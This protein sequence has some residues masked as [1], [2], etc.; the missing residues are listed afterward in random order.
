[1]AKTLFQK[2]TSGLV[3][4]GTA[5]GLNALN[6]VSPLELL[7]PTQ[8]GEASPQFAIAQTDVEEETRVRVYRQASPAVVSI[9]TPANTGSG[10]IVREDGLILTNAHVVAGASTVQVILADGTELTGDVIAF[11]DSGLDLAAVKVHGQSNLPTIPIADPSSVAV[12]QSAFAIGTPFGQFQN[13]FTVGIVSRIDRDRGLIQTDAAINPGNSGGPL[14][15]SRGELIGVNTSIFT[16]GDGGNIGLGFAISIDQVQPFL[17]AIAE[18]RASTTAQ[19]FP[20]GAGRPPEQI[21]LNAQ[22]IEGRLDTG[23]NVLPFDNSYYNTY[24]FE[25]QAGQQVIVEMSSQ[26]IDAYLIL[27]DPQGRELS[28]DDDSGGSTNARIVMRL[29]EDGTYT[30]LA[31]SYGPN[32]AGN[33]T[34]RVGEV[35]PSPATRTNTSPSSIL[36][37]EQGTLGRGSLVLPEDGSYYDEYSFQGRSGQRVTITLESNEFDPYLIVF[38]PDGQLL[39]QNDDASPSTT[40]SSISVTL[41]AS[42]T[43]VIFANAYDSAGEGR[44]TLTVR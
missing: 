16:T 38:S 6:A 39:A 23:S 18:G 24:L 1:M 43:Y 42:G 41:P 4:T 20:N 13:T 35:S 12:G 2:L 40:N 34:L 27:L 36:L 3:I 7:S 10:S 22:P 17:V 25:G 44:Y 32:E 30:L 9:E 26:E 21:A 11:A 5:V 29:P 19:Q 8:L 14:I 15:N 28:Q 37:Q 31:N 33:Y